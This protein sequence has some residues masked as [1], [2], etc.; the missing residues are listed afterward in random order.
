[1]GLSGQNAV[2]CSSHLPAFFSGGSM[3][4]TPKE[5]LATLALML[6]AFGFSGSDPGYKNGVIKY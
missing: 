5:N 6:N 2:K 3:P 4:W 1:M